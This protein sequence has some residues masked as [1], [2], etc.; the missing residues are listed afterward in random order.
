MHSGNGR[1]EV[2]DRRAI[3]C[4]DDA[5]AEVGLADDDRL[6]RLLHDYFEWSTMTSMTRYHQSELDVPDDL[7]MPH[8]SWDG[9]TIGSNESPD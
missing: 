2:M 9:L 7:G 3:A 1:H 5:L 6:R 4:F 8:W